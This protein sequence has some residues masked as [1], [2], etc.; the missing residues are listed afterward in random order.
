MAKGYSLDALVQEHYAKSIGSLGTKNIDDMWGRDNVGTFPQNA[1]VNATV[2][3]GYPAGAEAGN[4]EVLLTHAGNYD[5]CM[6]RYTNFGNLRMWVRSQDQGGWVRTWTPWRELINANNIYN[7]I[8][9]I[10]IVLQFDNATN[11]NNAFTGTVWEQIVDGRSARAATGP[12]AGTTV[13][14]I[15]SV[16]GSDTATIAVA[17]LPGHTHGMQNHTHSIAAHSHTMDHTHSIDHDHGAVN[18][19][20][21]GWHEHS[22]SGIANAAGEHTHSISQGDNAN[23][24]NGRVASSN[25]RETHVG[26]TNSAGNHTHSIS[27]TANGTGNHAHTVDLPNFTGTSGGSSAGSTGG[28]ALTTGGPSNNTTTST[29]DGAA[30]NVCNSVH[31]Y[32]FWKRVA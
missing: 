21:A 9:P 16:A 20:T 28:T 24:R 12:Q 10:G 27:G 7:A 13:G 19:S 25:S 6:Q 11:P 18:T 8:Y 26:G 1:N 30:L 3:N 5:N 15:G 29:G 17:N 4:L 2:A 22:L 23:V 14:Q 31:Y 32:A